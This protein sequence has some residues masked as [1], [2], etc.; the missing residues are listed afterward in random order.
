MSTDER[1]RTDDETEAAIAQ[2]ERAIRAHTYPSAVAVRR[3]IAAYRIAVPCLEC[4]RNRPNPGHSE[5][6]G[7]VSTE[8]RFRAEWAMVEEARAFI[9]EAIEI[10]QRNG[11]GGPPS[12]DIYEAAV[13]EVAQV[14]ARVWLAG[15]LK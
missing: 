10:W 12:S 13:H 9:D 8:E 4:E 15:G 7:R 14:A 2:V 5:R 11:M 3:I 6:R 1:F